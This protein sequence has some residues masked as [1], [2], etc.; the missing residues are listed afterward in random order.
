MPAGIRGLD[1]REQLLMKIRVYLNAPV[2]LVL[3]AR[4]GMAHGGRKWLATRLKVTPAMVTFM[5]QGASP[6][7]AGMDKRIMEAF[8][9]TTLDRYKRV[10]WDDLFKTQLLDSDGSAV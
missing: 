8:K 2:V 9:G 3:L 1:R 10:G 6:V 5:M 7:P 4:K